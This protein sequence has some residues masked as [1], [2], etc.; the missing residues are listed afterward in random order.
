MMAR[1]AGILVP[2]FSIPSS[3]S[4][5]V[6]EIDDIV[7]MARWLEAAG[8]R[9]LQLLPINEMPPEETS[10]YSAVSAMAIDPQFISLG[11][12]EDFA[13]LGGERALEPELRAVLDGVR[14][15]PLVDYRDVRRLK[16]TVLRRCFARFRDAEWARESARARALRTF[17]EEQAWWLDDYALFRALHAQYD[18]LAWT[19]WP[20]LL[21]TRE[22]AALAEAR[23]GLADDI[24]YRQYLQ[25]VAGS[26]WRRAREAA[27]GVALFGDLPFMVSGDSADVWA[28][29]DEFRLDASIGVPPDA[30]SAT[31]QDWGLPVYR[32]DVLAARDFDWLRHRARRN[33]DL[34]DGYRVDHLVGFYRTYF[35]PHDGGEPQFTPPDPAAQTALG[36]R[37]LGVLRESGAEITAED[38]GLVPD[39][40]R[41]SLARLRVPGYKVLRWE[42]HWQVDG[43]PFKDPV[44]YPAVA[45]ATSGTHDTEP[46]AIWWEEA[47]RDE[48]AAV[49]AVPS[50]AT[51]LTEDDRVR[52]PDATG[53][54][55]AVHEA[56]VEVLYGSGADILILPIQ[57]VFGWRDRI[58]VP[59]TPRDANWRW[60]LPWPVDRLLTEPTAMAVAT[61]LE[62]WTRR[63]GR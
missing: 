53:L 5:G 61:Q 6:G 2:L 46:M 45:V 27:R 62:E 59:A 32:W 33:A 44:D 29:Q 20:E 4:W 50:I 22:A 7:P 21:R 56:L 14:R 57:D 19:D 51:R 24:L 1:R 16:H 3:G 49:L 60:R 9:L 15:A 11:S 18:E 39:F 47:P 8:Q 58:N 43:Q 34:F 36:E 25:W 55:H 28:R 52:A 41:E 26:Q 30:F 13:A 23:R 48:K 31:G 35:R 12:L 42:R 63:Y 17:I 10:P 37:V 38:L 40:V 54:P